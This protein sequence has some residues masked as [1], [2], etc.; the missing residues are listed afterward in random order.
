MS[1]FSLLLL[2][3]SV[4]AIIYPGKCPHKYQERQ[5]VC[6]HFIK[7]NRYY[8]SA[9]Q[10]SPILHL[11][12]DNKSINIFHNPFPDCVRIDIIC[13]LVNFELILACGE[14][15]CET[16]LLNLNDVSTFFS[17]TARNQNCLHLLQLFKVVIQWVTDIGTGKAYLLIWGCRDFENFRPVQHE[18]GA[19]LLRPTEEVEVFLNQ[20][21][22]L[23]KVMQILKTLESSAKSTELFVFSE[24]AVRDCNCIECPDHKQCDICSKE[25]YFLQ[26][27]NRYNVFENDPPS[28]KPAKNYVLKSFGCNS[29]DF[30]EKIY[31][32]IHKI[33]KFLVL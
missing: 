29:S 6:P 5:L 9:T 21:I 30:F 28:K 2:I 32:F 10:F 18:E 24:S 27:Y 33:L 20:S 11:P 19:W 14:H 3:S 15:K 25:I 7:D 22:L 16:H 31:C 13:D 26:N 4:T 23:E 12:T 1:F 17:T 8:T